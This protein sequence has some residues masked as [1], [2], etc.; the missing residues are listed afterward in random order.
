M[1]YHFLALFS[2]LE[3]TLITRDYK[4]PETT[5]H[6]LGLFL[7]FVSNFEHHNIPPG[8]SLVHSTCFS[9]HTSSSSII[10]VVSFSYDCWYYMLS[11]ASIVT[12]FGYSYYCLSSKSLNIFSI[13]SKALH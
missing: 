11:Y 2:A 6:V 5:P 12:L 13:S 1:I 8:G 3:P 9:N 10:L 7:S 4:Y